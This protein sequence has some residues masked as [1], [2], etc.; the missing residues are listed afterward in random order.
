ML[1]LWVFAQNGAGK[2]EEYRD[3]ERGRVADGHGRGVKAVKTW[4]EG[5]HWPALYGLPVSLFLTSIRKIE[6]RK[7][8]FWGKHYETRTHDNQ[9]PPP[10][11][12]G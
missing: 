11:R 5:L 10:T 9:A 12:G 7:E 1:F 6:R 4:A 8:A 3:F 2:N